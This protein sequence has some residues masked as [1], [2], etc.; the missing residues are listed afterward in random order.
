MKKNQAIRDRESGCPTP[1][2]LAGKSK[3]IIH[4]AT[5]PNLVHRMWHQDNQIQNTFKLAAVTADFIYYVDE[6]QSD[7]TSCVVMLDRNFNLVS[8]N[9]LAS[10]DL[11]HVVQTNQ[12]LLWISNS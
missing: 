4:V 7:E 12:G 6:E 5:F 3:K 8:D 1:Y 2:Y 11:A 9:F 10:N